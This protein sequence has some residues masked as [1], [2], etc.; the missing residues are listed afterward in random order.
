MSDKSVLIVGCGVMGLSTALELAKS[1]YNVTAIDAYPVPSEWSA[2]NDFNK[3]IRNEYSDFIYTKLSIE[4]FKMWRSDNK[5]KGIFN[6]CGRILV[7]PKLHEGR[8]K[9]EEISINNLKKLG[10]GQNIEYYSGKE[11]LA[12]KFDFLQYNSIPDETEFKWNPESGL[13]HSANAMTVVYEQAKSLGVKFIFGSDG[14]ATGLTTIKGIDY[15]KTK[16][17]KTY[18]A[19]KIVISTGAATG[20]IVNLGNQQSA[21]GLFV[22]HIKISEAEYTRYKDIPILFDSDMGYF[23]PPDPKT[24]IMKIALPGTGVSNKVA[25]PFDSNGNKS[26]PRYK[27]QNPDDTMPIE[28]MGEAKRLLGRYVPELA[29]HELFGHRACWIADTSDS[30]FIIDKIPQYSRCYVASGDSGHA[31][32]LL[33]NIGKYIKQ[34]LQ[35]TLDPELHNYWKWNDNAKPYDAN[36]CSWRVGSGDIDFSDIKWVKVPQKRIEKL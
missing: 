24:R 36:E 2:A 12:N 29:Y 19:D 15:V 6:E 35:G 16:S 17:G 14:E 23:F 27:S 26:L 1:G 31:F 5:F 11:Q 21:T 30:H 10:Y 25:N 3:I 33:P 20:S 34:R 9:F 18:T 4:A 32:K 7:T 13:A 8:R 22:T 28:C